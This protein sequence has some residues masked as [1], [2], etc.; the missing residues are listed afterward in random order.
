[1]LIR[2]NEHQVAAIK[3]TRFAVGTVEHLERNSGL[4]RRIR[5]RGACT[6]LFERTNR[7]V[8]PTASGKKL[9]KLCVPLLGNMN[10]LRQ[11]MLAISGEV[12]GEVTVGLIL[13]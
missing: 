3:I 12:G 11:H 5:K 9:Y 13:L 7:G 8:T 10:A 4:C 1:M 6:K 2:T